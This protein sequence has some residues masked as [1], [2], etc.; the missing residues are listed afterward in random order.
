ML[1]L[2]KQKNFLLKYWPQVALIFIWL[3]LV[4]TN[5]TPG[6]YLAGWDNLQTELNPGLSVKRAFYSAWQEYQS[7]GLPAGMGHAADLMRSVVLYLASFIIPQSFIRYGF[8]MAMV[9][10]GALGVLKLLYF[11]GLDKNKKSFA[12]LGALS[13]LLNYNIIQMLFLP[14]ESFTI[15]AGLLPWQIWIYLKILTKDRLQRS[16][17][18]AFFM[19]FLIATS[20]YQALQLFVVLGMS[21]FL[22]TL[23]MLLKKTLFF[24]T[25]KRAVL[26]AVIIFMINSFWL[27]PQFH[28]LTTASDVVQTSKI[29]ELS[30]EDVLY[31]NRDKGNP[32]DFFSYTGFFSDGVGR[33]QKPLFAAWQEHRGNLPSSIIIYILTGISLIGLLARS[34]YRLPF[35]LLY[36][37]VLVALLNNTPPFN[38]FNDFIRENSLINQIFRS[39]FTKFSIL[40]ALIASYFFAFGAYFLSKNILSR[41]PKGP[42]LAKKYFSLILIIAFLYQ[43]APAFSGNYVSPTVRVQIPKA[44]FEMFDYFKSVDK[45]K[46]I[47]LLPEY[48]HWGWIFNEWGYDGSGFIWYGI[49]QP[50][51]SRNFDMWS[52][53]SEG[54]YWEMKTALEKEDV[55]ALESILNKY[56]IS[57]LVFDRSTEPVVASSKAIQDSR[58]ESLLSRSGK[59]KLIKKWDF[60]TLYEVEENKTVKDFVWV[61]ESLPNIGPEIKL[62]NSDT[63]Y[64]QNGDYMTNPKKPF[65]IYYPFLDLTTQASPAN[66]KWNFSELQSE[67]VFSADLPKGTNLPSTQGRTEIVLYKDGGS[68]NYT[69]PYAIS[70][71]NGRVLVRFPKVLTQEFAP[72]QTLLRYCVNKDGLLPHRQS[73][74]PLTISAFSGNYVCADYEDLSLDQKYGYIVKIENENIK[75]Q[76]LFFYALDKTKDQPYV[77]DRLSKDTEYYIIG[78]R[79]HQGVGYSFSFQASSYNTIPSV[80]K[81]NSLSVYLMPYDALKGLGIKTTNELKG[82]K[83]SKEFKVEKLAYHKYIVTLDRDSDAQTIILNQAYQEGWKAYALKNQKLK[84]KNQIYRAFPSIFGEEL[85]DHV[86]INN[87]AN[88]WNL[89]NQ[90]IANSQSQ[91]AIIYLPQYFQYFGFSLVVLAFLGIL[92]ALRVDKKD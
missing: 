83:G 89:N 65:D 15:F 61:A 78:D 21:L 13:Y 60:I 5:Y 53:K 82:A 54:Y 29:N 84:I 77:E 67:W 64:I 50:V 70:E 1:K 52:T 91:I 86:M 76:R 9:L 7:F 58:M 72:A 4:F 90:Q 51:V 56:G 39:P 28:F 62:T 8:H 79:F 25:I 35:A 41:L 30:T 26:S 38:M 20:S 49:E 68:V 10:V 47:G 42:I 81:I 92:I 45:N 31:R 74:E 27:F 71:S 19:I 11:A 14:Y 2:I 18:L 12:F 73:K 66:T 3:I 17:W 59:I 63:G 34:K 23:G 37:M 85:K 87:W 24:Q 36:A 33:N 48:T 43:G 55:Q 6:S 40:Y 32:A 80:N 57:Y 75:G 88:G 22:I 16:D 46:R 69:I 44:Y